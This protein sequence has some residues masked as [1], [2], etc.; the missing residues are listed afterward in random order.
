MYATQN[1]LDNLIENLNVLNRGVMWSD[2]YFKS[3]ALAVWEIMPDLEGDLERVTGFHVISDDSLENKCGQS[4][5]I[6]L[7]H[8][9]DF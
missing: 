8:M 5:G 2:L 7:N 6:F 1:I 3:M 4:K 9:A